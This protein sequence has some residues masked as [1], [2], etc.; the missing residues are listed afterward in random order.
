MYRKVPMIKHK[1]TIRKV[2]K[3]VIDVELEEFKKKDTAYVYKVRPSFSD[4]KFY[5]TLVQ[6]DFESSLWSLIHH[7][8]WHYGIYREI[9]SE[10][11]YR[12]C[13]D[14]VE[15]QPHSIF[16]LDALD[17]LTDDEYQLQYDIDNLYNEGAIFTYTYLTENGC[18]NLNELEDWAEEYQE[19]GGKIT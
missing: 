19:N 15:N 11:H 4:D 10:E 5:L 1:A 18:E 3:E 9:L 12:I 14:V 2:L 17:D 13:K 8:M 6:G 16:A 7:I